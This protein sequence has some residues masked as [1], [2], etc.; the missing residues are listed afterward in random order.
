M[1]LTQGSST[2]MKKSDPG[3]YSLTQQVDFS[4]SWP[5]RTVMVWGFCVF[6]L[7]EGAQKYFFMK[8]PQVVAG[9]SDQKQPLW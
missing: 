7:T 1:N 3:I 2:G 5:I 4:A 8:V 9:I 6:F